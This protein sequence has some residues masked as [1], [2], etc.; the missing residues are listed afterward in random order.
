VLNLWQK[1]EV[2]V[3]EVIQPLF[4]LANPNSELSKQME[5]Q[6]SKAG[7]SIQKSSGS[8]T[9]QGPG[10]IQLANMAGLSHTNQFLSQDTQVIYWC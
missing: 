2:F 10:T 7:M 3:S 9:K 1:N 6:V 4:D 8:S 5:E